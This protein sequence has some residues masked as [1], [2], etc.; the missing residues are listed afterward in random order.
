MQ[1]GVFDVV[2]IDGDWPSVSIRCMPVAAEATSAR[3][4]GAVRRQNFR[5]DLEQRRGIQNERAFD[6]VFQLA[7][8]A[9]PGIVS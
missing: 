7:H 2:E 1:P 5:W 6:E 9:G 4:S 8:V 3:P